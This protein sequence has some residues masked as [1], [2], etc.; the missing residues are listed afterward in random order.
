MA[1]VTRLNPRSRLLR[2]FD[3][4]MLGQCTKAGTVAT[5]YGVG[6]LIARVA[7][8]AR[9]D[10]KLVVGS[11]ANLAGTGNNYAFEAVPGSIHVGVDLAF[12]YGPAP[13]SSGQRLASTI[14][15]LTTGG[16]LRRG[17]CF[18]DIQRSW[19][20]FQAEGRRAPVPLGAHV[21]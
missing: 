15:D 18:A 7:Q 12:D 20:G 13:Y 5:F 3:S 10:G 6:P 4:F 9:A 11:S 2:S 14:L 1:L 8:L 16:F 19:S 21:Q 17:A